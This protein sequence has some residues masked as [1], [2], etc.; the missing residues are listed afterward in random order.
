[1]YTSAPLQPDF[2]TEV[3]I[4]LMYESKLYKTIAGGFGIP[5]YQLTCLLPGRCDPLTSHMGPR[6]A[7]TRMHPSMFYDDDGG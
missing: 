1:M 3:A 7:N 6:Y 4:K 5:N 2:R